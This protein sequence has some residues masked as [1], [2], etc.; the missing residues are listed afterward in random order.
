MLARVRTL[1]L[2]IYIRGQDLSD[3]VVITTDYCGEIRYHE[4]LDGDLQ[5]RRAEALA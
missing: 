3:M 5:S 4:A 2:I 1:Y